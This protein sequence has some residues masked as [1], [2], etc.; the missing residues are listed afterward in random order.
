LLRDRLDL[1]HLAALELILAAFV[2]DPGCRC[3]VIDDGYAGWS[4]ARLGV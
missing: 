2:R 3:V 4:W 1:N